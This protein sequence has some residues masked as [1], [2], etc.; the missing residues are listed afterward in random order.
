MKCKLPSE[1]YNY[2]DV[3]DRTKAD[4]LP[5]YR[6]YNYKLEFNDSFDKTKLLKSRIYL[7]LEYKLK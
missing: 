6:S 4:I 2:L 3:F 7:I 1:Y 5:L